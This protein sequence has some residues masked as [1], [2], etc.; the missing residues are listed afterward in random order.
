MPARDSLPL[1]LMQHH[2]K[3]EHRWLYCSYLRCQILEDLADHLPYTTKRRTRPKLIGSRLFDL[4]VRLRCLLAV[5]C[6][7]AL[8]A[9]CVRVAAPCCPVRSP[10][11]PSCAAKLKCGC[12]GFSAHGLVSSFPAVATI[13]LLSAHRAWRRSGATSTLL[14]PPSPLRVARSMSH[15]AAA[16]KQDEVGAASMRYTV[17]SLMMP[18][19]PQ[20]NSR[21]HSQL[22]AAA[23]SVAASNSVAAACSS[24]PP[25]Q[26]LALRCD[27]TITVQPTLHP[28]PLV[29]LPLLVDCLQFVLG[30]FPFPSAQAAM[31]G[32]TRVVA[33][34]P[35][36]SERSS[37]MARRER[38]PQIE[39]VQVTAEVVSAAAAASSAPSAAALPALLSLTSQRRSADC[40][41]LG[42]DTL[43]SWGDVDVLLEVPSPTPDNGSTVA[44]ETVSSP[45]ANAS[46]SLSPPSSAEDDP[47]L[48]AGL[49]CLNLLPGASIPLH[50]H[51]RMIE[52]ELMLPALS[53]GLESQGLPVRRGSVHRWPLEFPH[54]YH[55]HS[56]DTV[57]RILCLDVPR[58][59]RDLEILVSPPQPL[60]LPLPLPPRGMRGEEILLDRWAPAVLQQSSTSFEFPGGLPSQ[61]VTL[62]T[63]PAQWVQA[64]AV[65]VFVFGVSPPA[66][67]SD[68]DTAAASS[69]SVL[70]SLLFVHHR[71]RGW[72]LPGG[73]I[74]S[75]E[76]A[77]DAALREV[78]EESA[79]KIEA[80]SLRM[81]AQYSIEEQGKS[82]HVKSVFMARAA[83][84]NG[85]T[86]ASLQL[87]TDAAAF[88]SPPPDWESMFTESAELS[89]TS[90]NSPRRRYSSILN[91]NV[92]P[93]CFK[94][95]LAAL[96][97][98][99]TQQKT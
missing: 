60:L 89:A 9:A 98:P 24:S 29:S 84:A 88:I 26:Q 90:D 78:A 52:S 10:W 30:S 43:N 27:W 86:D 69:S 72:E 17:R 93:I 18:L 32:L 64:H 85:T 49:Y 61:T 77:E 37:Q 76:S 56:S 45:V 47:E 40:R 58:F 42:Q 25:Q 59:T 28:P 1:R 21:V 33:L 15:D 36:L 20:L 73:K 81:L 95:A 4:S 51:R 63:D 34:L 41:M 79:Q 50:I 99:A 8:R 74:D 55:N 83:A 44:P 13:R 38:M 12:K 97:A 3:G 22:R 62:H 31:D 35:K 19:P 14:P 68:A 80:G 96:T 67:A 48:S 71:Q 82:A 11:T 7:G 75:G 16:L 65:L 57:Q 39:G 94:M 66:A 53:G 6:G 23:G 46:S 70:P 5:L 87:E 2:R 54:F 92:Y 91:D